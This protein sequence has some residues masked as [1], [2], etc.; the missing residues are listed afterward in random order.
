MLVMIVVPVAEAIAFWVI[1]RRPT[2]INY[3][4][5][6]AARA[7]SSTAAIIDNETKHADDVEKPTTNIDDLP[8]NERP[9]I[10]VRE[11][12]RFVPQLLKYIIPLTMVYFLEYLINQGLVRQMIGDRY[13]FVMFKCCN[14]DPTVRARLLR[15]RRHGQSDAVSLAAGRLPAGRLHLAIV[16]QHHH[17]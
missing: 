7:S 12:L 17:H 9:L 13:A 14:F 5:L 8:E 1:L 10:G 15:E 11:K 3:D 2:T 16:R 4:A 6:D